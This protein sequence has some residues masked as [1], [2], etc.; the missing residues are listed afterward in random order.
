M[1][2][3]SGRA[4]KGDPLA[5]R[6]MRLIDASHIV[7]SSSLTKALERFPDLGRFDTSRWDFLVTVAGVHLATKQLRARAKSPDRFAAL[8]AI[9]E[10]ELGAWNGDAL[11][12]LTDCGAFVRRTREAATP[13]DAEG[14][15]LW[16]LSTLYGRELTTGEA[17]PARAIGHLLHHSLKDWWD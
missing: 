1:S 14:A 16:V 11:R 12:A 9:V 2:R 13:T 8:L 4:R 15:A 7:A 10:S 17:E 6:A 5:A 3:L